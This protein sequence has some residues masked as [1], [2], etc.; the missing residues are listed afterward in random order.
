MTL[1]E[2]STLVAGRVPRPDQRKLERAS[3]SLH[4]KAPK[5]FEWIDNLTPAHQ[6]QFAVELYRL[7][8]PGEIAALLDSWQA[9][10][11]LDA[12][13][14]VVAIINDPDKEY[15]EWNPPKRKR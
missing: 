13:P 12:A 1:A 7:Y 8:I 10:A 15:V 5:G 9:T 6:R 14:E 3:E 11:E 2:R 4:G